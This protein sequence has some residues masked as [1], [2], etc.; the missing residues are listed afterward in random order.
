MTVVVVSA[1]SVFVQLKNLT[2]G[3]PD[4]PK[5]VLLEHDNRFAVFKDQFVFYD[6]AQPIRLPGTYGKFPTLCH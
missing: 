1:P 2:V 6:F 4:A 5:L 3:K